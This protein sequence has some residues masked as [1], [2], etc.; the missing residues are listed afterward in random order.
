MIAAGVGAAAIG[1]LGGVAAYRLAKGKSL[2][3]SF[4]LKKP[5][6]AAA[7]AT[8]RLSPEEMKA[9][10]DAMARM[11]K[12]QAAQR[13]AQRAAAWKKRQKG[14][15]PTKEANDEWMKTQPARFDP[16]FKVA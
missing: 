2:V 16:N 10:T 14:A 12:E 9:N 4:M 11:A 15:A 5:P 6:Q 8:K 13:Q 3:P 1:G 7:V